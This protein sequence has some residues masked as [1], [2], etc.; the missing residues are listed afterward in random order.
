MK[1]QEAVLK[2]VLEGY[3]IR[4]SGKRILRIEKYVELLRNKRDWAGLTSR[5]L[6]EDIEVAIAE[7]VMFLAVIKCEPLCIV[8]IGSGGGLLG[9][10]L[11]I[12]CDDWVVTMVESSS[13]KSAF[14]AEVIGALE[15]R[16]AELVLS[17]VESLLGKR[18]FDACVSR[19]A[20]G[21]KELAPVA[22]GL[23]R[24]GGR[25][26]ALKASGVH[27]EANDA[28]E[29]IESSR[30]RVVD[31]VRPHFPETETPQRGA[32]LVVIEKL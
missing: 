11:S 13:R 4:D 29:T 15:I 31:I 1:K 26:V 10:V 25:Y 21:L 14:L 6:A 12:V 16:N 7:S 28:K 2:R 24:K 20:G 23:L 9:V 5:A 18:E 19:A 8:E 32:S 30:G 27:G 22:L 3:G 17:R